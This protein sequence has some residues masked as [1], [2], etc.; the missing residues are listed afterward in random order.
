[1]DSHIRVW[2]TDN[3]ALLRDIDCGPLECWTLAYSPEG[4]FL[5]AGSQA[6][7]V[8]DSVAAEG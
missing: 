7:C 5:A 3:G 6:V 1:M 4:R 8:V 2:N